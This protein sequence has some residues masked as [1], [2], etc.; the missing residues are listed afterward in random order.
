MHQQRN[1]FAKNK[2]I[3]YSNLYD[4]KKIFFVCASG[5]THKLE[6]EEKKNFELRNKSIFSS[7]ARKG[8]FSAATRSERKKKRNLCLEKKISGLDC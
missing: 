6:E 4:A 1:S 3:I 2:K 7:V 8:K 5:S